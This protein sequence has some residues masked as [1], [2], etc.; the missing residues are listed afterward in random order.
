[1][2][3]RLRVAVVCLLAL[4]LVPAA[5][6]ADAAQASA[7]P[8][9]G[10]TQS[11]K[12][13][14]AATLLTALYAITGTHKVL[15]GQGSAARAEDLPYTLSFDTM[16]VFDDDILILQKLQADVQAKIRLLQKEAADKNGGPLAPARPAITDGNGNVT[17][18]AVP[19]EA[20]IGLNKQLEALGESTRTIGKLNCVKN[21]DLKSAFKD[22]D[23]PL[24]T[25][26]AAIK[27]FLIC[28]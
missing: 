21:D 11:I 19:S 24:G 28:P 2:L 8:P 18:A 22:G 27:E 26:M 13:N 16:S 4:P 1:M 20:Q 10:P 12:V 23:H 7:N 6:A 17:V 9:D 14:D 25:T 15:I 5:N 3:R